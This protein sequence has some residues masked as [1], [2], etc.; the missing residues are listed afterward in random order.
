MSSSAKSSATTRSF[1]EDRIAEQARRLG[2]DAVGF[3]EARLDPEIEKTLRVFVGDGHHGTMEW[4]ETRIEQRAQPRVLWPEVRSIIVLG[5]SYAPADNALETLGNPDCGNISVYARNRD[6]HDVIKGMLKHLAQFVVKLGDNDTQV[7]VFV[8]TAPVSE[9]AL[10]EKAQ[11]GWTGKHTCLVSRTQ[12]SW[13]LLGEIYTTLD[14]R[15][16]APQ[17]GSCGT[18]SRCL[19]ACPTE[20]FLGPYQ[21][22]ARRCISYL[23]IEHKGPIPHELREKVGNRIYGCD[24]CLAVC[25]WNRFAAASRHIKMQP[26]PELVA[27]KLDELAALDD[28]AFRRLFSGS[29]VKRIGRDR[30]VRNVLIAIGNSGDRALAPSARAL[31]ADADEDVAETARWALEKLI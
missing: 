21:M 14:L 16:S 20:A 31:L 12:G 24:D 13:L 18:C 23:T 7:K 17:G 4:M 27:P 6:Y 29:P 10:A 15:P 22:D 26:R 5:V 28:A 30:F 19:T 1:L 9:R 2:F 11:L 8:D 25:P 3:C